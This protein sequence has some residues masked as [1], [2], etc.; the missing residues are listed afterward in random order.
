MELPGCGKERR[1]VIEVFRRNQIES[2][3]QHFNVSDSDTAATSRRRLAIQC[4][5][6]SRAEDLQGSALALAADLML[7]TQA[8]GTHH[9]HVLEAVA[10]G[11]AP[12]HGRLAPGPGTQ[13]VAD[14]A[15]FRLTV[16]LVRVH[17][18]LQPDPFL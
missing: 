18:E 2:C 6:S 4:C 15:F 12:E 3:M 16:T 8:G 11:P 5:L 1:Q 10:A 7:S 14:S 17:R 13:R 9:S